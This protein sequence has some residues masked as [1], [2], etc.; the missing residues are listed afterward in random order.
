MEAAGYRIS[1][2]RGDMSIAGALSI[3]D[4]QMKAIAWISA[5]TLALAASTPALA[6]NTMAENDAA[7]AAVMYLTAS[8]K[9]N[10]LSA[11]QLGVLKTVTDQVLA[12]TGITWE[13]L[14]SGQKPII[15]YFVREHDIYEKMLNDDEVTIESMCDVIRN[16]IDK[17]VLKPKDG[18]Q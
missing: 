8:R 18:K 7:N 6:D 2:D 10:N 15:R 14:Q 9:C 13:Y 11:I 16:V 12:D 1:I 5:C 17:R 4:G 3:K